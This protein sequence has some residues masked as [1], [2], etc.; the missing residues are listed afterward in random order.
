MT[1]RGEKETWSW[2]DRFPS[3]GWISFEVTDV[4]VVSSGGFWKL[5]MTDPFVSNSSGGLLSEV[6]RRTTELLYSLKA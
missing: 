6:S 4:D 1:R 3:L 2:V 5:S